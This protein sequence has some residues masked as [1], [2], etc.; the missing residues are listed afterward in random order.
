M[1]LPIDG[2]ASRHPFRQGQP[3]DAERDCRELVPAAYSAPVL[4]EDD[5]QRVS[6]EV[7]VFLDGTH[8][9]WADAILRNAQPSY[10]PHAI[11]LKPT[12][13]KIDIPADGTY[14]G[15]PAGESTH[16][17]AELRDAVGGR[18]PKGTDAVLLLTEKVMF[19][20]TD[21][22]GDGQADENE[23]EYGSIGEAACAGGVR[24]P[25]TSFAL[26]DAEFSNVAEDVGITAAHELGHLLGG[27]HHLANCTE[28][29]RD[30]PTTPCT[31][32]WA[33][34]MAI[35]SRFSAAN[36]SVI[37]GHAVTFAAP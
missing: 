28:G 9:V 26:V 13:R 4:A 12:Y 27:H 24:W 30:E 6:V 3:I 29:A 15:R 19:S 17:F 32:M 16:L 21:A 2:R 20:F 18:R 25:E 11:G 23:R 10:E 31:A 1:V 5:G 8:R 14:R 33:Y 7:M 34:A 35:S 22:D 37:R 36:A